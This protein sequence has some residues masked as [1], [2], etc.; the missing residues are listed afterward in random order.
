MIRFLL[1]N[2]FIGLYTILCCIW[3]FILSFFDRDGSLIHRYCARPWG[4][5]ILFICGVKL[6]VKGAENIN[7]NDAAIY[8]ANHQSFFDIFA[9]LGGLPINFKFILKEELMRVPILG[10]A[11]KRAGYISL[12]REGGKKAIIS[13]NIAADKIRNGVSVLIFPEGTRSEDGIVGEFKKGGFHL[14]LKSGRDI[15][16]VAIFKS[17][18]I[19]R[20]GSLKINKGTI[21]FRIGK[22]IPVTGYS[23]RDM[24]AL[25]DKVRDEVLG[26]MQE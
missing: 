15:V 22:A 14:A 5:L 3:A 19:A 1:L 8:M 9:L 13:M 26:M 18:D 21:Y 6:D 2:G 4:K 23:K 20:K 7:N 24:N 12:D 25:M 17:R 10:M 16:P 11:M